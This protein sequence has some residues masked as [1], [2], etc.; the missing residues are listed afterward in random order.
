MCVRL[1]VDPAVTTCCNTQCRKAPHHPI[2]V[3]KDYRDKKSGSNVGNGLLDED[4]ARERKGE[5]TYGID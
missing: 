5:S 1:S 3:F 2:Y 4:S